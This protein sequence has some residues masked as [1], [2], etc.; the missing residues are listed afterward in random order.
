MMSDD[1]MEEKVLREFRKLSKQKQKQ[2]EKDE[3]RLKSWL[4]SVLRSAWDVIK[5]AIG[6]LLASLF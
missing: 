2:M 4:K 1:E 3:S 5:S 6:G